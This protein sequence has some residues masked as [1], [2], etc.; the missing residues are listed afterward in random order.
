MSQ[1]SRGLTPPNGPIGS[2]GMIG[3]AM[4]VIASST[5]P[6]RSSG[7]VMPCHPAVQLLAQRK[8]P[9][10][11]HGGGGRDPHVADDRIGAER[12]GEHAGD[13]G[14]GR[15]ATARP[16]LLQ[17]RIAVRPPRK[18]AKPMA[19][20][21]PPPA[22]AAPP[23]AMASAP[24]APPSSPEIA[25]VRMPAARRAGLELARAPAALEP[26]QQPDAERDGEARQQLLWCP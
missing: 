15:E 13:R 10:R 18:L 26:D 23:N 6:E 22:L 11:G 4:N 25:K 5:S 7:Q 14:G 9:G 1:T 24:I 21:M 19:T 12:K 2:L 16:V 3:S 17:R 8:Q 20:T